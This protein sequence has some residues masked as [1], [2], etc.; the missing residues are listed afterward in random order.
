[1]SGEGAYI[2]QADGTRLLD[3][4]GGGL[5][6]VTLGYGITEIADAIADQVKT[7]QFYSH[8]GQFTA[9]PAAALTAALAERAPETLNRVHLGTSGSIANETAIRL[10]HYYFNRLGHPDKKGVIAFESAYHGSTLLTASL[11]G[12]DFFKLGFDVLRDSIHHVPAPNPY[13]RPPGT[14]IEDFEDS[15]IALLRSTIEE[16]GPERIACMIAEPILVVGGVIVPPPGYY[17]R[18]QRLCADYD[19]LFV[20][21]EVVTC[22]GRLGEYFSSEA[23][24]GAKPDVITCAKGLTSGYLP[25][26]AALFSDE[27]FDVIGTPQVSGGLLLTHGFTY[28][29]HPASCAAALAVIDI[30]ERDDVCGH[31]REVGPYFGRQ[32]ATL[33]DLPMVGDVR[34]SHMVHAVELVADRETGDLFDHG[35]D[36]SKRIARHAQQRGVMLRPLRHIVIIA[37][38]I[39]LS[40]AEIDQLVGVLRESIEATAD[41]LVREGVLR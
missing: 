39:I 12:I 19:I 10:I 6:A 14:S 15:Q 4:N 11:T 33:R 8:F 40:R 13:R 22:F 29:G 37:P 34:G 28:S 35:V 20:A 21:D 31:V 27:M 1:M 5:S 3:G 2:T 38:P 17:A 18:A 7:L 9:P 24:F 32:L 41:D 23:V 25:L 36:I 30:M 26:S 16:V